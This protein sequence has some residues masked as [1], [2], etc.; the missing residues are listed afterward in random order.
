MSII[1]QIRLLMLRG[2]S[3]EEVFASIPQRLVYVETQTIDELLPQRHIV[4]TEL[5][6]PLFELYG[7]KVYESLL[8]GQ[9]RPAREHK[10]R[11][12]KSNSSHWIAQGATFPE[13]GNY[14]KRIQK[15]WGKRY[16]FMVTPSM[17]LTG[18]GTI[19]LVAPFLLDELYDELNNAYHYGYRLD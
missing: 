16:G 4:G 6:P 9:S 10:Q 7:L 8:C 14:H 1:D 11:M 15:K 3:N 19:V 17:M 18:R 12:R 13:R 2:D 5:A